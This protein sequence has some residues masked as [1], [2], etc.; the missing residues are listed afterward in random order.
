[1]TSSL[2]RTNLSIRDAKALHEGQAVEPVMV[3][4]GPDP[5]APRPVSQQTAVEPL[6]K[7]A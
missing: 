2:R 4:V 5:K 6:G 1:M 7:G 3:A